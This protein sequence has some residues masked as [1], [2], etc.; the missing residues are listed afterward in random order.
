MMGSSLDDD[1]LIHD[2]MSPDDDPLIHDGTF[3][4]DDPL[5]LMSSDDSL[6]EV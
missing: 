2:V 5:I 4:G 6:V 3:P 1:P